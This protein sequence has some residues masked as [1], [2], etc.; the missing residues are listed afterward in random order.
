MPPTVAPALTALAPLA[1][2][3]ALAPLAGTLTSP[4]QSTR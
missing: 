3:A 1:P 4:R 2:L